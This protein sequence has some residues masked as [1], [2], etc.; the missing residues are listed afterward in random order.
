MWSGATAVNDA[1]QVVGH[2]GLDY[3]SSHAF[4]TGPNGVGMTDLQP[5]LAPHGVSSSHAVGINNL[6]Q[7]V[8]NTSLVPEPSSYVLMLAGLGLLIG[9]VP[10]CRPIA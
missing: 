7:V 5:L 4:I 10:R 9:Y 8:V 6:G 3:G 2:S 1:G